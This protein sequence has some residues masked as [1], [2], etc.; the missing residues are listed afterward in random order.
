[1]I[2]AEEDREQPIGDYGRGPFG[3][4]CTDAL[5][6]GQVLDLFSRS[7]DLWYGH[8]RVPEVGNA[9]PEFLE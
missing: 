1:M 6:G 5:Y 2:P 7:D 4:L 8:S 3:D 9:V